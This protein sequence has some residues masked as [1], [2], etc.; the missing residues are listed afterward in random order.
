MHPSW[1]RAVA[2]PVPYR[3]LEAKLADLVGAPD[4]V[5]FPTVTLAHIGVLPRLAGRRRRDPHRQRRA[6]LDPGGGASSR[7]PAAPR[8]C[9]SPTTTSTR[10]SDALQR[11]KNATRRV[12][13]IDGVYSISGLTAPLVEIAELAARYDAIVYVDDAHGFGVLGERP[14]LHEPWGHRGN[15]VVRHFGLDYDNIVYVGG[16][17][18]A[19]SSLAAFVTANSASQRQMLQMASTAVFSGPIPV[20][21]LATSLAAIEVNDDE[22]DELRTTLRRLTTRL[23]T[24]ARDIGFPVRNPLAFPI[25]TVELGGLAAVELGCRILWEQGI[26]LTPA[27]FP[28]APL[29]RGGVRFTV[30]SVN[31]AAEVE[32]LLTGLTAGARRARRRRSAARPRPR[33]R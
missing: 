5:V 3:E 22:G 23:V 24:G 10:S 2:S 16:L 12:I 19:Y 17:S 31:T 14:T 13:A 15:G 6:Q 7:R 27:V 8:S 18:K 9:R 26:L 11:A 30:T 20:A 28:A 21:S 32:G 25:V 1:T 29:D 4:V 33:R